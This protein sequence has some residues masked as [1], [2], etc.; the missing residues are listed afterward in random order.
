MNY[1]F[2]LFI[3]RRD[4]RIEDNIGL[5]E[6]LIRSERVAC[7]FIFD[8][9]QSQSSKYFSN[10]GFQFLIEALEELA[11]SLNSKGSFLNLFRG[12][13]EKVTHRLVV[14]NSL[15][16]V[17]FNRDYTP[18]SRNR[19]RAIASVCKSLGCAV[20]Q[21][22]DALLNPPEKSLKSNGTP[23]TIFTPFYKNCL[24]IPIQEPKKFSFSNLVTAELRGNEASLLN[25]LLPERNA[26]YAQK[27][28]RT[29]ALSILKKIAQ[30]SNY[31]EVRDL[32]HLDA[33]THLSAHNKF[34]TV[35]I[36]QIAYA[37][38]KAQRAPQELL[39]QLYWRDFFTHIGFNFPHVFKGAFHKIYDQ[40]EWSSN[41]SAFEAW[42][43][44]QTGFPIVDAGMRELNSSGFM[45]NRVRMITASFLTKD[46]HISWQE[47][48]RYFANRLIDY[49]PCVNNGS[50]Q[51][52]AS[53]GCDAQPYFR[54]F[55]PWLQQEKFDR[56]CNYI[57]R[58]VPEL[59]NLSPKQI[60]ALHKDT[61]SRPHT[62]PA[63]IVDHQ[64]AKLGAEEMF[65]RA[66]SSK[67]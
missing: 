67:Y 58:W 27:G 51:W 46:L 1:N 48:E 2:S 35:S 49:D 32:P 65:E 45:Q 56:E 40:L 36:R 44:G 47:G 33:T 17:F 62:Y 3:F 57:K 4:L 14:E 25:K 9:R 31:I 30:F 5:R 18:F 41:K 66:K 38:I 19:D 13:A 29:A 37:V 42:C 64:D 24:R 39:R 59:K 34:G 61:S 22:D 12:E 8:P 54:I 60:H 10:P 55:N 50:W 6:A 26:N 20:H 43:S 16:A 11:R 23:Y 15:D 52:A 28:G 7:C 63:P 21:F 53:T